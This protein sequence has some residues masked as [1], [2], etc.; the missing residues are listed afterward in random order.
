MTIIECKTLT[1]VETRILKHRRT[2]EI[3]CFSLQYA[4]ELFELDF[5]NRLSLIPT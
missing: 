4:L 1:S 3:C 5:D 2:K